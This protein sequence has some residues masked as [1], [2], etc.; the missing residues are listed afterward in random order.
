MLKA[1]DL[2]LSVSSLLTLQRAQAQMEG[3]D[4]DEAAAMQAVRPALESV[5]DELMRLQDGP[6]KCPH[7]QT[8]LVLQED[9]LPVDDYESKDAQEIIDMI[10]DGDFDASDLERLHKWERNHQ[11][12]GS[13]L[14]AIVNEYGS[15]PDDG[16][17]DDLEAQASRSRRLDNMF[18]D[19]FKR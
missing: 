15:T 10:D 2:L 13:I 5:L 7:C 14:S 11:K 6:K 19:I 16:D 17:D 8:N 1:E 9:D 18:D 12:R 4:F 3:R